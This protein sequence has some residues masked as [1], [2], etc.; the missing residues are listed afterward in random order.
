MAYVRPDSVIVGALFFAIPP[1]T[2]GTIK[3]GSIMKINIKIITRVAILAAMSIVLMRIETPPLFGTPFLKLDA[4]DVPAALAGIIFGPIYGVAVVAIKNII[5]VI[6]STTGGIGEIANF[7]YGSIIVLS[8][9]FSS[10]VHITKSKN[11]NM[12][13]SGAVGTVLMTI[14][15][16]YINQYVVFPLYTVFM[17]MDL[18]LTFLPAVIYFNLIKGALISVV[19]L[20]L[21][22]RLTNILRRDL[23]KA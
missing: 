5:N 17:P 23:K 13:I 16:Y 2:R 14:A 4:A 22:N 15:A 11:I 18:M 19:S 8:L 20:F 7:L 21:S 6:P 3:G 12:L 10:R 1:H 9:S